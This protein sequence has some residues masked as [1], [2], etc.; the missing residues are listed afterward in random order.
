MISPSA[1]LRDL[2]AADVTRDL[3]VAARTTPPADAS[4]PAL[5]RK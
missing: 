5:V 3:V 1:E 2:E 4:R